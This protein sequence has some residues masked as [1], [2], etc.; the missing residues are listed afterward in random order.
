M[1]TIEGE[2]GA[3]YSAA[4]DDYEVGIPKVAVTDREDGQEKTFGE[5]GGL[6]CPFREPGFQ[7]PLLAPNAQRKVV[8]PDGLQRRMISG[9]K[10]I[11]AHAMILDRGGPVW[12]DTI[13]CHDLIITELTVEEVLA[14]LTRVPTRLLQSYRI[15]ESIVVLEPPAAWG[16]D[17]TV[18]VS[19]GGE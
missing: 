16:E 18:P 3:V 2:F 7:F 13:V 17:Y 11:Y 14:F 12:N 19:E 10:P 8:K 9:E 5:T 15:L 4:T 1:R 6:F